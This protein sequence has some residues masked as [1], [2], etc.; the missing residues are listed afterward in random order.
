[1]N[2]KRDMAPQ[3]TTSQSVSSRAIQN[4]ATKIPTKVQDQDQRLKRIPVAISRAPSTVL[5]LTCMYTKQINKKR[6]VWSDGF[7]KVVI[8]GDFY[9]CTLIDAEDV[10]EVG[11]DSRQLEPA[12]I[13]RFIARK[14]HQLDMENYIVDIT[15]EDTAST[16]SITNKPVAGGPSLK[17]PKFVP[18]SRY[19][20]PQPRYQPP[21]QTPR[22]GVN[23]FQQMNHP[24]SMST[25]SS[26]FG[27]KS[28][29]MTDTELDDIWG[30]GRE[31]SV[32]QSPHENSQSRPPYAATKPGWDD[33]S[34]QP[35]AAVHQQVTKVQCRSI[36]QSFVKPSTN[37]NSPHQSVDGAGDDLIDFYS[38]SNTPSV[39]KGFKRIISSV[40]SATAANHSKINSVS[41]NVSSHQ[42]SLAA[43]RLV[44]S[45]Y[46]KPPAE[47]NNS[48]VSHHVVRVEDDGW[49]LDDVWGVNGIGHEPINDTNRSSSY[50]HGDI[51]DSIWD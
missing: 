20:P 29:R 7:L 43:H 42:P 48:K 35:P 33:F 16:P 32:M 19:I 2:N 39:A 24:S 38:A 25:S 17:L 49:G 36:N 28:Y 44:E 22:N 31:L 30:D 21:Q 37:H 34:S 41:T 9:Q 11:L 45:L 14:P 6:K 12:E 8:D 3:P 10:R 18:P 23:E 46:E 13:G 40:R 51:D 26:S 4:P 15:F 50:K 27:G 47:T 1:M 5:K